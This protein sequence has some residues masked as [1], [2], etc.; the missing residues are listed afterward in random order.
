MYA[1]RFIHGTDKFRL[2]CFSC[3]KQIFFNLQIESFAGHHHQLICV[4]SFTSPKSFCPSYEPARDDGDGVIVIMCASVRCDDCG[5]G[6]MDGSTARRA[7][8]EP[9]AG[10]ADYSRSRD[11]K[12]QKTEAGWSDC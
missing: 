7:G 2:L 4:E 11:R 1:K 3:G 8:K 5:C 6:S 12:I 9:C 10:I